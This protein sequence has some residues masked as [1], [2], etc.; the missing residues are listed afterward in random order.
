MPQKLPKLTE[1]HH[2]GDDTTDDE[3]GCKWDPHP[4]TRDFSLTEFPA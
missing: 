2:S 1:R 4:K 3:L